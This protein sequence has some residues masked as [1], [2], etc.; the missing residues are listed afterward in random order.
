MR[1]TNKC[2]TIITNL[3]SWEYAFKEV[4][5]EPKHW[6]D[7]RSAYSLAHHF[8]TPTIETSNGMDVILACLNQLGYSNIQLTHAEIEHESRFD[9]YRGKGRMQD[10]IVW[11]QNAKMPIAICIEAKVDETFNITIP[12]AYSNALE[13]IKKKPTSK[14]KQRIEDLCLRFLGNCKIE[15]LNDLRYQ[16]LYYLAGSITEAIK[17]KGIAYLPIMVY[18]TKDFSKEIGGEN[19][20]DYLKFMEKLNFISLP[21]NNHEILHF[22]GNFDGVEIYTSYIDISL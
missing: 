22:K 7:G 15:E 1:I 8:T 2:G 11:A 19:K 13:V 20:K 14:A 5:G 9:N 17:I 16:L 6:R 10:M 21:S 12:E 3:E 18:H 4:D